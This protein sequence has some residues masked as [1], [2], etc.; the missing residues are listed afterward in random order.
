MEADAT[1]G[2]A[3]GHGAGGVCAVDADVGPW[4][5]LKV[6]EPGAVTFRAGVLVSPVGGVIDSP[7]AESA[8]GRAAVVFGLL[9]TEV[10]ARAAG[11]RL[12][13]VAKL[14]IDIQPAL[15]LVNHNRHWQFELGLLHDGLVGHRIYGCLT[16]RPPLYGLSDGVVHCFKRRRELIRQ[17]GAG[18][19]YEKQDDKFFHCR[20]KCDAAEKLCKVS[21]NYLNDKM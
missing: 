19:A 5:R 16:E 8:F 17:S 1:V 20:W 3:T 12:D 21:E 2:V 10:G 4:A 13:C 15:A 11:E 14:V 7:N 9:L 6:N 18:E